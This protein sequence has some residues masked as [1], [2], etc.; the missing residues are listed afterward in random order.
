MAWGINILYV[1]RT[2]ININID[3]LPRRINHVYRYCPVV[4]VRS[5]SPPVRI[6]SAIITYDCGLWVGGTGGWIQHP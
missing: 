5:R 3:M 2:N 4:Q 6:P 1:Y